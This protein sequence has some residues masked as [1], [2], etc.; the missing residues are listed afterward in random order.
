MK[1]L[2]DIKD[3][4]AAFIMELLNNFNYVKTETLTPQKAE[5]LKSVKQAVDEMKLVK[6]GKLKATSAK[7]LLDEL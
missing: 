5:V 1:V 3:N 4:K 2:L 7:D 6:E